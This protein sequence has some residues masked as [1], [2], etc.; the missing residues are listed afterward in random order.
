MEI[1]FNPVWLSVGCNLLGMLVT[2]VGFVKVIGN[3]L[4][5]LALDV[6]DIKTKQK[7]IGDKVEKLEI[8]TASR[9]AVCEERHSR[10][11][12]KSLNLR[13]SRKK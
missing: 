1:A 9:N 3:D 10:R 2:V 6:K 8:N 4:H 12:R 7:E 13:V 5:H 11:T